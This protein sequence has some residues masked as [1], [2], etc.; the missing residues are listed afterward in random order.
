MFLTPSVQ[1]QTQ[2]GSD[3]LTT[4]PKRL[5]MKRMRPTSECMLQYF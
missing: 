5:V 4:F 3:R 2:P 1:N